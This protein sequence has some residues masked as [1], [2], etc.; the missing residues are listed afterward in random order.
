MGMMVG[1]VSSGTTTIS[2]KNADGTSAGT[3]KITKQGRKK[4]KRLRYDFKE[5]SARI[6]KAKTSGNARAAVTMARS[7]AAMLRKKQKSSEYD[8]SELQSAIIH[9]E[10]MVRIAKKRLKHLQEEEKAEK[11]IRNGQAAFS[12]EEVQSFDGQEDTDNKESSD[13]SE[14]IGEEI[15]KLSKEE[16]EALMQK[17]KELMEESSEFMEEA[18]GLEELADELMGSMEDIEPTDLELRKKKHRADELREI[19]EADMKYLKAMFHR[20]EKE[21]QG[22]SS[23]VSLELGGAEIPVTAKETPVMTEGGSI[24]ASV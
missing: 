19:M 7:K 2:I 4:R 16:L 14:E 9:A 1:T 11:N 3:I 8:D 10:K 15:A 17:M 18:G 23:G 6:L 20:L 5:V 12:E 13:I 21:K 24:D 22:V